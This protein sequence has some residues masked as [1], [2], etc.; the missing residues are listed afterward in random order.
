VQK[1][2]QGAEIIRITAEIGVQVYLHHRGL[3]MLLM[4][5]CLRV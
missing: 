4:W 1:Q 5:D 3:L 2:G